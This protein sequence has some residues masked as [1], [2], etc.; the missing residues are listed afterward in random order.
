M[1]RHIGARGGIDKLKAIQTVKMTRTVA[2]GI[3]TTLRVIVYK[4]R[5][6]S[7]RLEQG[8]ATPGSPLIPRGISA[9]S[10]WDMIQGKPSLR[11]DQLAAETRETDGDFDGLLVDWREKGHRVELDGREAMPGGDAYKLKVTLKSGLVRTVLVDAK[12]FLERRHSGVL[13]LPNNRQF[14][15]TITF[16]NWRD[17]NGVMFPFDI[18]EERTGKEPVVTLVTYTDKIEVNVPLDDALFAPPAR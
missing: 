2:T 9:D 1:A 8:P 4:K 11:P 6:N 13:N 12:T 18:T 3:G 5:P 7:M 17:V 10:V 14:D 16:D 15:V